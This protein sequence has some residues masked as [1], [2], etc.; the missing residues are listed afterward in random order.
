MSSRVRREAGSGCISV[1]APISRK[2]RSGPAC[3]RGRFVSIDGGIHKATL[4]EAATAGTEIFVAGSEIFE[5]NDHRRAIAELKRA[6]QTHLG[7]R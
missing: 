4:V 6:A 1:P 2:V 7:P 3:R 5:S